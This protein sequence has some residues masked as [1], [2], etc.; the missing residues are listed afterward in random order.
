MQVID[1]ANYC[2]N[3]L[4]LAAM[5]NVKTFSKSGY[6]KMLQRIRASNPHGGSNIVQQTGT[7]TLLTTLNVDMYIESIRVFVR[8][9]CKDICVITD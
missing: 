8:K 5:N 7:I 9:S 2:Y 3:E 6:E 1:A 4:S